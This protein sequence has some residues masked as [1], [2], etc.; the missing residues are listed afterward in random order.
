MGFFISGNGNVGN[1]SINV[2]TFQIE[3]DGNLYCLIPDK[4]AGNVNYSI[5]ENGELEVEING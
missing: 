2:A 5:N 3:D 1:N 4:D